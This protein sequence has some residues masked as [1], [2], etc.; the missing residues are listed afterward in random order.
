MTGLDLAFRVID[1]AAAFSTLSV[2][3]YRSPGAHPDAFETAEGLEKLLAVSLDAEGRGRIRLNEAAI[4]KMREGGRRTIYLAL[5]VMADGKPAFLS[6]AQLLAKLQKTSPFAIDLKAG[7]IVPEDGST[8]RMDQPGLGLSGKA[9]AALLHRGKV[10]HE[11]QD[12]LKATIIG[13]RRGRR[14][15]REF[16]HGLIGG[17]LNAKRRP[18]GTRYVP[19]GQDAGPA[20]K[21]G[22][23]DGLKRLSKFELP[24]FH[25]H[26][27]ESLLDKLEVKPGP[28]WQPLTPQASTELQDRLQQAG[29]GQ[30]FDR[31]LADCRQRALAKRVGEA[32]RDGRDPAAS[33]PPGESVEV[34]ADPA[35]RATLEVIYER[36]CADLL[37]RLETGSRPGPDDIAQSVRQSISAGPADTTAFYDFHTLTIAW[38]NVWTSVYDENTASEV[39]K[40]YDEIVQ[41]VGDEIAAEIESAE[42]EDLVAFVD[43]LTETLEDT[44]ELPG[45]SAPPDLRGW[46][47]QVAEAW[48]Y[49]GEDDQSYLDF[50]HAVHTR[51]PPS[52]AFSSLYLSAYPAWMRDTIPERRDL[53]ADA[54]GSDGSAGFLGEPDFDYGEALKTWA[55]ETAVRLVAG[56][57]LDGGGAASGAGRDLRLGRLGRLLDGI[58]QRLNREPYEFD[59]FA[60]GSYNYGLI[61]TYQQK[62]TPLSYQVGDLISTM[63]LAP[64]ERKT[65][66]VKRKTLTRDSRTNRTSTSLM[67]SSGRESLTRSQADIVAKATYSAAT[68]ATFGTNFGMKIGM[69][70]G[71]A[72]A[73]GTVSGNAASDSQ[74]TKQDIRESTLKAAQEFKDERSLEVTAARESDSEYSST[75]EISNPNNEITVTYL[76]Y[77]LQRRF[78]VTSRLDRLTPVVMVAF[79]V[80]SPSEIDEDWLLTHDW[81]LRRALLDPTLAT[82]LDYIRGGLTGDELSV[83]V[84]KV[85]WEAQLAAVRE[86]KDNLAVHVR[87]RNM[88]RQAMQHS[89][90]LV[91]DKFG[92]DD[93]VGV[94]A[95]LSLAGVGRALGPLGV[96]ASTLLGGK[97]VQDAVSS[98]L[99]KDEIAA[100]QESARLGLEW[101]AADLQAAEQSHQAAVMALEK[102]TQDYVDAVRRRQEMRTRID[103]L[104]VHVKEN[105]LYYMQAIWA[106]EPADQR[107][108]RLYAQQVIWPRA[109]GLPQVRRMEVSRDPARVAQAEALRA[110]FDV[111]P[112]VDV[113][114]QMPKPDIVDTYPT[115]PLHEVA[116]LDNLI[117]FKGNYAIFALRQGNAVT[118]YMSAQFLDDYFGLRDPDGRGEYP[119]ETEALEIARCMWNRA[120][121]SEAERQRVVAWLTGVLEN[122]IFVSDEIVVPSGEL[123]IEALPGSH[124]L[125]E[126]FKLRHRAVDMEAA[127]QQLVHARIESLRHV[128]RLLGDE[129]E[130]PN[131]DKLV[132]VTG[133]TDVTIDTQ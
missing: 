10:N 82:A 119:T 93:A 96:M 71:T 60:P 70:N 91:A 65:Y 58:H 21:Q 42:Y 122:Q 128:K 103:Q 29:A 26:L 75:S 5:G 25:A 48:P 36:L 120:G 118:D 90:E 3:L 40:V 115:R 14:Q 64:G 107:Y 4:T 133:A 9:A 80:P 33:P 101:A 53:Q 124:P 94:A 121:D 102:A 104:R 13:R 123:F 99:S 89:A 98:D 55:R 74:K 54:D 6:G 37:S 16:V 79:E 125:L 30:R 47:P 24:G 18:G 105:I 97:Q 49:L 27:P 113:E 12:M 50:L 28:R 95:G 52:A 22:V 81:I 127:Q 15:R 131:I 66:S 41:L 73:T 23:D 85:Q 77:E 20:M 109:S 7:R 76:F 8:P 2:I 43:S 56:A 129:L 69:F 45:R 61:H 17:F 35:S 106:H 83:E 46:I 32:L 39:G 62:W 130:D 108:F 34:P 100:A 67:S 38:E 114:V 117:G 68:S 110:H 59:V 78:E 112:F 126:D 51:P 132:K 44:R 116:D 87:Y 11:L 86:L 84:L 72:N 111:T 63:P 92:L 31:M 88:T 57:T 19:P 1:S